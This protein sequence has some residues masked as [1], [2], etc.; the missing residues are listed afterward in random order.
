[1]FDC[2]RFGDCAKLFQKYAIELKQEAFQ[3]LTIYMEHLLH[4][5]Q[6]LTAVSEPNQIWVRH[7]LDSAYISRYIKTGAS[8]LDIGTGGGIP[9]I[10]LAILRPDLSV[11]MLDSESS[12]IEFCKFVCESLN[13]KCQTLCGRAEELAHEADY[14]EQ[15]DYAVSRAMAQGSMLSELSLPF[16]KTGGKL[17]AMKGRSFDESEE[18]FAEA[19]DAL[20][21]DVPQILPYEIENE[22]KYLVVIEKK[23]STPLKYP[24]RF[25]KIKRNPL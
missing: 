20:N 23:Q 15:F 25:A 24:R 19:A 18:R 13:L 10:P 3:G 6:N 9:A 8:V 2:T 7:F 16:V 21:A 5:K 12:K 11:T 17:L 1:M 22:P 14:R 4:A